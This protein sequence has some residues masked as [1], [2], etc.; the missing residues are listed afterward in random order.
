MK[1]VISFSRIYTIVTKWMYSGIPLG[2]DLMHAMQVH[3]EKRGTGNV[4][5]AYEACVKGFSKECSLS[6]TMI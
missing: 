3:A 1:N 6:C 2:H 5:I 4:T